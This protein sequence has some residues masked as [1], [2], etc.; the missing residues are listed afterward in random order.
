MSVLHPV[1]VAKRMAIYAVWET[2]ALNNNKALSPTRT[3]S[4]S[5]LNLLQQRH[6]TPLSFALWFWCF[7]TESHSVAK[8]SLEVMLIVQASLELKAVP[9]PHPPKIE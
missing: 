9:L 8:A 5:S 7:E 1:P 3:V 6:H 4:P 2:V